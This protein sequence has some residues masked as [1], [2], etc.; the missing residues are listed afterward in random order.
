MHRPRPK[1]RGFSF[2]VNT[3]AGDDYVIGFETENLKEVEDGNY[4]ERFEKLFPNIKHSP[5]LIEFVQLL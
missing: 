4:K 3:I 2:L 5:E 1:G